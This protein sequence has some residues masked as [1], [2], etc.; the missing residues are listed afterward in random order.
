VEATIPTP[1][2]GC[3]R[4]SGRRHGCRQR[5]RSWLFFLRLMFGRRWHLGSPRLCEC[6]HVINCS[7][8]WL[9][10]RN[11][12]AILLCTHKHNTKDWSNDNILQYRIL[13]SNNVKHLP[14]R[15]QKDR[16][17]PL[18]FASH[19]DI[20]D[21]NEEVFG[22]KAAPASKDAFAVSY[23]SRWKHATLKTPD[24]KRKSQ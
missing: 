1:V 23:S 13:W 16:L 9:G 22:S 10:G 11:Y 4:R 3:C 7:R 19:F 8:S 5:A 15:I 21:L 14:N 12:F 20:H 6:L 24:K 18:N 2:L 17:V